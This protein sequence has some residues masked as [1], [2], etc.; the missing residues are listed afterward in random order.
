M[1]WSE[2]R[3]ALHLWNRGHW[4]DYVFSQ[5]MLFV[6]SLLLVFFIS[7]GLGVQNLLDRFLSSD[8][9]AEQVRVTPAGMQAGFFQTETGGIEITEEVMQELQGSPIV[10]RVDP[11]IYAHVPALLKGLL[12]G[13][14]YYTD[15][16]MEG[17]TGE[18]LGDSILRDIDWSYTLADSASRYLPIILS[19]NLLL[20]YNAAFA[21]SNDLIGLTPEGVLGTECTVTIGRSSI[22][23][24]ELAPVTVRARIEATSRNMNLFAIGVPFEFVDQVNGMYL[25]GDERRYSALVIT[26]KRA[27]DVPEIVR[28]VEEKGLRAETRRGI[29]QKAEILVGA[30]TAAL[31]ALAAAILLSA[32]SSA[33]HTLVMDL[34]NRRFALG[35]L[36]A[37]GTPYRRLAMIFAFQIFFM[38]ALTMVLGAALGCLL[39]WG[40]SSALLSL[41]PVLRAAVTSLAVFPVGWLAAGIGLM[42]V[43]STGFAYAFFG[44]IL[45]TPVTRLLRP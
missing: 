36:M 19:E 33:I 8:L 43:T 34:K 1:K 14:P 7:I 39:A 31:S 42:L 27:E 2:T 24:M 45:G 3:M 18:F 29:A 40:A 37:L 12:G 28:M 32:L 16:T 44:R 21:E 25:P 11:Q 20:L 26:A 41:S 38:S 6:A 13:Q 9:P 4:R 35:V 30:V 23:Q 5:G 17:V 22:A 10:G 15:I